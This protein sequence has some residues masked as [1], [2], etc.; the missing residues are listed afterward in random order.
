MFRLTA[1]VKLV[2]RGQEIEDKEIN[3]LQS[4]QVSLSFSESSGVFR[5]H[6]FQLGVYEYKASSMT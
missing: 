3:C 1:T 6:V 4:L 2:E 5:E